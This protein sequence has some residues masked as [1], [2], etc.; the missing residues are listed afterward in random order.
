MVEIN[1]LVTVTRFPD[2]FKFALMILYFPIGVFLI[3]CRILIAIHT[4]IIVCLFPRGAARRQFVRG[5]LGVLGI[6]IWVE[7]DP[8]PQQESPKVLV[9][10]YTSVLDHIVIDVVI[11]HFVPYHSNVPK[12]FQWLLGY[13]DLTS[14]QGK[15]QFLENVKKFVQ[16]QEFPILMQPEGVPTNNNLGLLKFNTQAFELELPVQPVSVHMSRLSFPCALTTI[17]GP[18]WTD[19]LWCFFTPVTVFKLKTHPV[20][21]KAEE[22]T[23]E[24][25]IE[26]VRSVIAGALNLELTE[27]T[28]ADIYEYRKKLKSVPQ[29]QQRAKQPAQTSQNI[30][31]GNN[32]GS[33][34][35]S[36][37]AELRKMV[38]QVKDVLPQ[39]PVT[40]VKKD[41]EL[42]KDVDVT[43][44]NILEGRVVYSAETEETATSQTQSTSLLPDKVGDLLLLYLAANICHLYIHAV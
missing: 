2:G 38:Q 21:K 11:S 26:R 5:M 40:A 18:T 41:L 36:V 32:S 39:V 30:T 15:Q 31:G 13:K 27:Y 20:M 12:V 7:E 43:I 42:T 1:E 16:E 34:F 22:E 17:D 24:D 25:F 29:A 19:V 4:Y 8:S 3:V 14:P 9:A 6:H 44:S 23:V 33:C 10:N 28:A 37:D 35:D